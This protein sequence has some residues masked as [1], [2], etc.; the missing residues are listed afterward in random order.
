MTNAKKEHVI[1]FF[2]EIASGNITGVSF[3]RSQK[4]GFLSSKLGRSYDQEK[5]DR[6]VG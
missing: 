1:K 5:V 4:Q 2:H 3:E 6:P